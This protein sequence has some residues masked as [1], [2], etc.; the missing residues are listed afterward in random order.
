LAPILG[1]LCLFSIAPIFVSFYLSFFDYEVLH[2]LQFVGLKNYRYAFQRDDVF[3]KTIGNT[4]YYSLVSVPL[5]MAVALLLAQLIYSH[6]WFKAFF[7]TAFFMSYIVPAVA[8]ALVWGFIL[9]ASQ[10]GL[11]NGM[12]RWVG[13][14]PQR[15][16]TSST[17]V[18]PSLII[19]G[20]W[21]G[22]GYNLVLFL[23]G[24]ST[25]PPSL[26]EAGRLDGA[27]SWQLFWKITWPL[28]APT[29]LFL[30]V[31]GTIGA[32][33]VFDIP[34]IMTQ[35]SGGPENASR[36]AI[37]WVQKVGFTEFRM[38]YASALA[39]IF[40]VIILV[41]TAVQ[42]RYLRTRWSY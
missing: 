22:L 6:R 18:I 38:G 33:Q 10:F 29:V 26:Y 9:Q 42:L 7:R 28:L 36:M 32:L 25:I 17:L 13:I 23:A 20:V 3:L 14:S 27:T 24:L 30:V 40:F 4:L 21:R 12:L 41:L 16:L 39:F 35:G 34:Y 31:T 8:V 5:G 2:S 15:W 1:L 11:L 19:I 37:M